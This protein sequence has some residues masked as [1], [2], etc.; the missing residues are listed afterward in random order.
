MMSAVAHLDWNLVYLTCFA[1]GLCLGVLSFAGGFSHLHLGHWHGGGH[2]NLLGKSGTHGHAPGQMSPLN[3]FTLVAFLCWFGGTGYLL[4]HGRVFAWPLVFGL[5]GLSGLAGAGL[6]YW[7]MSRVLLPRERTLEPAD[8]PLVGVLGRVSAA[9]PQNGVGE[10]LYTQGGARRSMPIC[11]EDGAPISR[12][13]EVVVL[14]FQRGI[15][16]V[17]RWDELQISLL[18]D[19]ASLA[20]NS[21]PSH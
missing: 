18:G 12:N 6:L 13:A 9:V 14:R 10:M 4:S 1:V 21:D 20:H 3:G 19:D 8:T 16:Y 15:G 2:A 17:R 5:S 7:F 11:A